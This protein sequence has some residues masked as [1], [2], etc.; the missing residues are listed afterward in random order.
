MASGILL[1]LMGLLLASGNLA[2]IGEWSR[3][4]VLSDYSLQF[5]SWLQSLIT[6]R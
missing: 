5:E 1:V 6:G 3:Q 2:T 4:S